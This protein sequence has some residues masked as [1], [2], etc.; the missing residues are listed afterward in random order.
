MAVSVAF[1]VTEIA[2]YGMLSGAS[3]MSIVLED[4]GQGIARLA[5]EVD[6]LADGGGRDPALSERFDRIITGLARQLRSTLEQDG[7]RGRY[8]VHIAVTEGAASRPIIARALRL[9]APTA[10]SGA[11][12]GQKF[13]CRLEPSG[14]SV[15]EGFG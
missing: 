6:S 10:P 7:G 8:A 13:S 9:C 4:E 3:L 12:P 5:L 15:V 11:V 2:E 14:P 1:L